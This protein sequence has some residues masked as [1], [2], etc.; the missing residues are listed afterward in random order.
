MSD[1]SERT[2]GPD[3]S[4]HKQAVRALAELRDA[5]DRMPYRV[6][7]MKGAALTLVAERMLEALD[8]L[9]THHAQVTE[10]EWKASAGPDG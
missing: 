8:S 6:P 4:A 2:P 5:F 10:M 3:L 1:Q 9:V 7:H